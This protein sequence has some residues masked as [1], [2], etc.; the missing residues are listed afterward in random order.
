MNKEP[1][2]L[3]SKIKTTTT[4]LVVFVALSI[5]STSILRSAS[6]KYAYTPMVLS[7]T[8][9]SSD[10]AERQEIDY[11]LAYPGK[12]NPD[13]PLWYLK[14]A[15]DKIW[16]IFT[17]KESKKADLNLLF[18]DK[19]LVSSTIL[20]Q[21]NKPDLGLTTLLK[22]EKYL[23]SSSNYANSDE[24]HMKLA[25]ASLKHIEIVETQILPIAPEDLRP[26]IIKTMDITNNVY[27][28]S[29][30]FLLTNGLIPP[31]NPFE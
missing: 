10:Q 21:E 27:E 8:S 19:R 1:S 3:D 13:S 29:K 5:L 26:Q 2:L 22:A 17:I 30:V 20:F 15:R 25:L 11:V 7:E 12:I 24:M 31:Q 28:K 16:S 14:A 18:A 9:E 6:I 4:V 23:E